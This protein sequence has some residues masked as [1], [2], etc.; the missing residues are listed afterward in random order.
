MLIVIVDFAVAT[1]DAALAQ[2]TLDAEAPIIRALPG[3]LGYSA[4]ASP[5]QPGAFRLMHEWTDDPS[6]AAYRASD[7][8]KTVGAVLFPLM[9]GTPSSRVF[10]AKSKAS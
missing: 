5:H 6:F 8:F 3:N 4:W 10:D 1:S 7:G 2:D 9:T